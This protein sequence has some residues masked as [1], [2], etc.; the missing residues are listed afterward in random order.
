MTPTP[1]Q[2]LHHAAPLSFEAVYHKY[3]RT[4]VL[5]ARKMLKDEFLADTV[6]ADV[7]V[8]LSQTATRFEDSKTKAFLYIATRNR[9]VN[10]LN[11]LKIVR[12]RSGD[13]EE[14]EITVEQSF[15]HTIIRFEVMRQIDHIIANLPPQCRTIINL[16][17]VEGISNRS[18]ALKLNISINTVRN[19]VQRGHSLIRKRLGSFAESD[20]FL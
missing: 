13:Y 11:H 6:A 12:R 10:V 1:N 18:I 14:R 4:M 7:F 5:F 20:G 16:R 19:Q 8:K 2:Y 9:C 3:Y 17:Y 15:M